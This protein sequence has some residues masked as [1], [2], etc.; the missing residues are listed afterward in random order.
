MINISNTQV[1]GFEGAI[2]GMQ[3]STY[4]TLVDLF[5]NIGVTKIQG[6]QR[7]SYTAT[8]SED[9]VSKNLG[10]YYSE[11]EAHNVIINHQVTRFAENIAKNT[12][13]STV[14][15]C[16][17]KGYFVSTTGMVFDRFGN[18]IKGS[19]STTGYLRT[20]IYINSKPVFKQFH[21][22][23]AESLIPNPNNFPCINHKDGN[24][25][26]NSIDN[27]EWCTYSQNT[28][29]AFDSGL[30]NKVVGE[31]HHAHKLT[32][33]AVRDIRA[34]YVKGSRIQGS[35]YFSEKYNI[36]VTVV[37]DVANYITWRHI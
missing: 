36:D 7:M 16:V 12:D 24:K 35:K 33:D 17:Y 19:L 26:N 28:K 34:N 21:R 14:F 10:T 1:W 32:N 2:R 6:K 4:K 37:R 20:N 3:E 13:I 8:I 22:M 5:A 30:E 25:T 9:N 31:N 18:K 15:P 29:H 23:I 27:L 11:K